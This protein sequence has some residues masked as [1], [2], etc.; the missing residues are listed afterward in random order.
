MNTS[1]IEAT[2]KVYGTS[3]PCVPSL[4][5]EFQANDLS[6]IDVDAQIFKVTNPLFFPFF[7]SYFFCMKKKKLKIFSHFSPVPSFL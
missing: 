3:L 5:L 7:P 4:F 2:N 6:K 1:M